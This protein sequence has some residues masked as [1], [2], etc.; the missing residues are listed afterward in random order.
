[1]V[2]EAAELEHLIKQLPRE[3]QQKIAAAAVSAKCRAGRPL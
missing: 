3:V 2:P 1:M